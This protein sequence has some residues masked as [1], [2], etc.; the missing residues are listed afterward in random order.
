MMGLIWT[1]N[2][3]AQVR[4][5]TSIGPDDDVVVTATRVAEPADR[6]PANIALI[7][8]DDLR[9]RHITDL[10]GALSLIAGVEAPPGGDAGPA[11]AVP[12]FWGLHEFDAFLLVVDGVP[13]GGAFNPAIPTLDLIDVERIEVLKGSAPVLFGATS[14][15]GVIQVIHYPAGSHAANSIEAGYGSFG[16][17]RA[18]VTAALPTVLG[19]DQSIAI[20]AKRDG[21]ADSREHV[22]DARL[23]YRTS[24]QVLNGTLRVDIDLTALRTVPPSPVVRVGAILTTLTPLDANY[25]PAD[26]RI[27]E[28]RYHGVIG[29]TRET[30]LWTW[31]T[32]ASLA[33]SRVAD[34]RGFL[35]SDLMTADSQNQ[36]RDIDDDYFDTDVN[37]KLPHDSNLTLGADLLYGRGAQTSVNGGYFPALQGGVPLPPT[38]SLHVDEINRLLDRRVFAGQY[39]QLDW[40]PDSR[41]DLNAGLR[42]NETAEHKLSTHIDGFDATADTFDDQTRDVTR[43]SGMAGVSYRAWS[44]GDDE[45]VL[46]GD[47]RD[48]FKPS[49]LDFGPDNTPDILQPESAR[50]YEAGLKGRLADGRLTYDA[51]L[52]LLDFKNLVVTT[53][54]D[55]GDQIFQNAGGERLKGVELE[56]QWRVTRDLS[57]AAAMSWHDARFTRYIAAEGGANIDVS[58][59]QLPLSPDWLG[60]IGAVYA[61]E[62]GFFGS[63]TVSY[64]GRRMLDLANT[65]PTGAYTSLDGVVGYRWS[66][67]SLSLNAY[68]LTD[69]RRPVSASEFGD[70]SYYLSAPRKIFVDVKAAF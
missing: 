31:S 70:Q 58:G 68:N 15:V 65:A 52:F 12:S 55:A 29:Y 56:G 32:T 67:Y 61:P 30:A 6:V 48:T 44:Q 34:I 51:S 53:T 37:F 27:D 59:N 14:F 21:F 19:F 13:W 42:V 46:Y 50:S 41:W 57:I 62:H 36:R 28:D 60:S 23:L 43:L 9:A 39:A 64:V 66:R 11:S 7:K 2:A 40:K 24:G 49:A 18:D 35:R 1:S 16:S 33:Y 69:E 4:T 22:G 26:A 5:P 45:L 25:N 38:T 10:R 47:Y 3:A 63:I 54:D 17:W 20:D 8:G